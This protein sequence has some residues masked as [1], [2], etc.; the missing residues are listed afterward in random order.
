MFA[1]F[2]D[3][4]KRAYLT[5]KVKQEDNSFHQQGSLKSNDSKLEY[6]NK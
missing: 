4:Y 6:K 3:F 1:L 2:W 5:K